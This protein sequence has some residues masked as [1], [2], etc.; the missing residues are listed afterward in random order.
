MTVEPFTV[1]A[2]VFLKPL[3]VDLCVGGEWG[4]EKEGPGLLLLM[5][6]GGH[7]A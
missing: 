7:C 1:S 3:S 5:T 2:L 4:V 6:A